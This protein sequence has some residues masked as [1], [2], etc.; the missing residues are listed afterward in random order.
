M[1]CPICEYNL[2]GVVE[3]RCPECGRRFNRK[4]LAALAAGGSAPI[5]VWD[6]RERPLSAR[7]ATMCLLTWFRPARVGRTFPQR[8]SIR[9]ARRFRALVV[10]AG[11]IGAGLVLN[12]AE[13]RTEFIGAMFVGL[14]GGVGGAVVFE[15]LFAAVLAGFVAPRSPSQVKDT[16]ES[17]HGLVGMFRTFG[18]LEALAAAA[19][20]RLTQ[21]PWFSAAAGLTVAAIYVIPFWWAA[22]LSSA[23]AAKPGLRVSRVFL[24]SIALVVAVIALLAATMLGLVAAVMARDAFGL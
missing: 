13:P 16:S 17:W 3:D 9:S 24:V 8:Y 10:L 14:V 18:L 2:T 19:A 21:T 7:F 4:R 22:A 5:P 11:T 1:R 20:L 6:E 23:V 12:L 15:R